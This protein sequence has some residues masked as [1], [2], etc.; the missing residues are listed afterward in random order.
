MELDCALIGTSALEFDD[1]PSNGD[2][3]EPEPAADRNHDGGDK[4]YFGQ[5][6][7]QVGYLVNLWLIPLIWDS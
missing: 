2:A 7:R 6:A 1:Q 3:Q 5:Q 4:S